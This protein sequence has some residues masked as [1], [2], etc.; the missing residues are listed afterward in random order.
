MTLHCIVDSVYRS[1]TTRLLFV[2]N[3]SHHLL[4]VSSTHHAEYKSIMLFV[5]LQLT[6]DR[7]SINRQPDRLR[8]LVYVYS[9]LLLE[10]L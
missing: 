7:S 10:R 1:T 3:T 2:N 9:Y 4:I 5:N 6:H 8:A